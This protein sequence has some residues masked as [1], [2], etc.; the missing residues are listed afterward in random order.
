MGWIRLR[1]VAVVTTDLEA[2]VARLG[3]LYGLEVAFNDP[4]VEMF[5]LRNALLPVGTQFIEVLT[6]IRAGTAAGRQLERAG[7]D[8]GYMVICHTDD[9]PRCR[10]TAERLGVRV[11]FEGVDHGY[12]IM[13]LHPADTGGSFLE[14]DFQPGGEDPTGPWSPAG[15]DWQR[16]VHTQ[17]VDGF[18]SV[19]VA[20]RRPEE[21]ARK[22]A[23]LLDADLAGL[24]L[25]LDNATVEFVD[26]PVDALVGVTMTG[27][28]PVPEATIAGVRFAG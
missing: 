22:W 10:Q 20:C 27:P 18:G 13:Q 7:G 5:G 15:P 3:E 6:P 24:S 8:S 26:G 28:G 11:A 14:V 4:S 19:T 16:A 12:S 2:A 21:V 17:V 9:Q 1:Q 25:A 23:A